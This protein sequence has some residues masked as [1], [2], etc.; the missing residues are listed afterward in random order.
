[1]NSLL[2]KPLEEFKGDSSKEE[3]LGINNFTM[4]CVLG[5]GSYAKVIL[6]KK[7]DSGKVYALKILKKEKIEIKKQ[8]G[9]VKQERNILVRCSNLKMENIPF[10]LYN[11]GKYNFN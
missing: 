10:I 6:A 2:E 4:L 1:M 9:N 3:K 8:Q 5:K 11:S 7:K